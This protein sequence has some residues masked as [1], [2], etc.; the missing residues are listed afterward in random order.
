MGIFCVFKTIWSCHSYVID[1]TKDVLGSPECC[2]GFV[3]NPRDFFFFAGGG[4]WFLSPFEKWI[5]GCQRLIPRPASYPDVS[6]LMK[7]CA[8]RKAGSGPLRFI[9][10]HSFRARL[11]H[12]KNEAPEE[13]AVPRQCGQPLRNEIER[14]HITHNTANFAWS[15]YF[16]FFAVDTF[17]RFEM[18]WGGGTPDFNWR[19]WLKDFLGLKFSIPGFLWLA[20]HLRGDFFAYSKQSE[21]VIL[22]LLMKQKKFLGV[23]S[24]PFFRGGGVSLGPIRSS[25]HL[26]AGGPCPTPPPPRELGAKK[27]VATF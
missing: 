7:M 14:S 19:G 12:A 23:S 21:V 13:E 16:G 24:V 26:T 5:S 8:Q 25:R 17:K 1:E 2:L 11:C 20:F 9:T 27:G 6:L 4:G 15:D 18:L 3:G 22:M 10:S